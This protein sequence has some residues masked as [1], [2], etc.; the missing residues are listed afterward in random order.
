MFNYYIRWDYNG[1]GVI[2]GNIKLYNLYKLCHVRE[3]KFTRN[4][5]MFTISFTLLLSWTIYFSWIYKNKPFF[6]PLKS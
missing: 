4:E 2:S 3:T 6:V 5:N 1:F